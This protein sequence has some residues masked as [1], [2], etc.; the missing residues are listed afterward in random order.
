VKRGGSGVTSCA[1]ESTGQP[2]PGALPALGLADG[3]W[4][5]GGTE[6][7]EPCARGGVQACVQRRRITT[8]HGSPLQLAGYEIE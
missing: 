7:R 1:A 6:E 8:D 3:R 4:K 5:E 2:R